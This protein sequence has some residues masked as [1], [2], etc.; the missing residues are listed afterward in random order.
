MATNL[1]SHQKPVRVSQL[2]LLGQLQNCLQ[3]F[4]MFS[5]V[6]FRALPA[7]HQSWS[8]FG[9]TFP[10]QE[11]GRDSAWMCVL[12]LAFLILSGDFR[13]TQGRRASKAD[14]HKR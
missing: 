5:I 11:A 3:V 12:P 2:I 4:D 1:A 8:L 7:P 6:A 9:E 14:C 13:Q 10:K